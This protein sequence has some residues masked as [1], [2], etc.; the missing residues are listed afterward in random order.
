MGGSVLPAQEKFHSRDFG[1]VQ[2]PGVELFVPAIGGRPL[3]C[4][5]LRSFEGVCEIL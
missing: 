4:Y 2:N 1:N 3:L 5:F